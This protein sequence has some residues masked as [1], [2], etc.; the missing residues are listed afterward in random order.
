MIW[1]RFGITPEEALPATQ[2]AHMVALQQGASVLRVHDVAEAA[3]TI[4]RL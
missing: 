1:K 3:Q 4:S 2:A